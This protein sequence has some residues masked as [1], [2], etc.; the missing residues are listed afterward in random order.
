VQGGAA[1][2]EAKPQADVIGISQFLIRAQKV[3]KG[4]LGRLLGR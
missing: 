1:A 4:N 2:F 3:D